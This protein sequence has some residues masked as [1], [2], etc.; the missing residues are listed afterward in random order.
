MRAVAL[1]LLGAASACTAPSGTSPDPCDDAAA[2]SSI[3]GAR[4]VGGDGD[5]DSGDAGPA[6]ALS[7]YLGCYAFTDGGFP[8]AWDCP[9]GV[10]RDA[11]APF[12][13]NVGGS[14]VCQTLDGKGTFCCPP[15]S[16]A[17]HD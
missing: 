11:G 10:A 4:D 3:C 15:S 12:V 5:G 1:L 6:C 8:V 9:A 7:D 17:G 2:S 14:A 16:D 13:S